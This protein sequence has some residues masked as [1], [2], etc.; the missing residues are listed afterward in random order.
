METQ[1]V[2]E[3]KECPYCAEIIKSK[4]VICRYCNNILNPEKYNQ[5]KKPE[6]IQA[7][8]KT[9]IETEVFQPQQPDELPLEP[10]NKKLKPE[11][12]KVVLITAALILC[13][14]VFGLFIT[15]LGQYVRE[16]YSLEMGIGSAFFWLTL[17]VSVY[18]PIRIKNVWF[19]I[20]GIP[21][22]FVSTT[23]IFGWISVIFFYYILIYKNEELILNCSD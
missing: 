1:Q 10:N 14:F 21:L 18:F 4:A 6:P 3:T 12:K 7:A 17:F 20:V 19:F 11:I 23:P 15:A 9:K 2:T 22:A 13:A 8:P 5:L 16:S